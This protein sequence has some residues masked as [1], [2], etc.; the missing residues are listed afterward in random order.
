MLEEVVSVVDRVPPGVFIDATVGGATHSK[1]ILSRRDDLKLL[2]VDRF[3]VETANLRDVFG[4]G[5]YG[6]EHR[7]GL[8]E[9]FVL[10]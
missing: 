3:P 10:G 7:S 9:C 4:G 2:A 5:V 1:A 6:A 8:P